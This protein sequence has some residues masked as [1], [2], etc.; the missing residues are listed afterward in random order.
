MRATPFYVALFTLPV[1]SSL[2]GRLIKGKWWLNDFDA[3]ICG[4]DH[5]RRGLSPYGLHPVCEGIKPAPFVYPPSVGEFFAPLTGWLSFDALRL[6][7]GLVLA[8]A[9]GLSLWYALAKPFAGMSL[10]LRVLGCAV[11]TGSSIASGNIS[12]VLHALILLSALFVNR[13]RWPFVLTVALAACLKPVMLTYLVVLLFQNRKYLSRAAFTLAGAALGL[14][15]FALTAQGSGALHAEWLQRMDQIVL[16]QQPGI[17]FF[18]WASVFGGGPDSGVWLILLGLYM[19]GLT[20]GG[21]LLAETA[22]LDDD[23]RVLL[24]L[25]LALLLNPRLMDYDILI[26]GPFLA[27]MALSARH[28]GDKAARYARIGLWTLASVTLFV[29]MAD[30]DAIK[31]APLGI[32]LSLSLTAAI[33][34]AVLWTHRDRLAQ[35]V[36]DGPAHLKAIFQL[37]I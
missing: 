37:R 24:G 30:I 5:M 16:T 14:A 1:W 7:Y 6:L 18:A 19:L 35:G 15:G 29:S 25:G 33:M 31:A 2:L 9:V 11:L 32:F 20:L 36:K 21:W 3:L 12:L 28:A 4:A 17:S 22:G 27:L 23:Q 34:A 13:H 8:A 26:L 10:R